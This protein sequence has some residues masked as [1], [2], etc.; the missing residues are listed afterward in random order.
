[1]RAPFNRFRVMRKLQFADHIS[2]INEESRK[3]P[4]RTESML[5]LIAGASFF[6]KTC[7]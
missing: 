5:S 1:M 7:S 6:R 2:S 4:W 3:T